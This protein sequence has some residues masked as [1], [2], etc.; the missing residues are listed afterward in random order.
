VFLLLS[1]RGVESNDVA[2]V[3]SRLNVFRTTREDAKRYKVQ[4]TLVVGGYNNDS[5][6]LVDLPEVRASLCRLESSWP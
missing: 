5:R 3:L 2:P 4:M 1:R 6:E